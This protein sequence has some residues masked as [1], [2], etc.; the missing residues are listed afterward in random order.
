LSEQ[1]LA[2]LRNA[3]IEGDDG[4]LELETLTAQ[5]IS[6][7]MAAMLEA[8]PSLL[9]PE[10]AAAELGKILGPRRAGGDRVPA[11]SHRIKV[12]LRRTGGEK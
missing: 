10:T 11:R 5:Q 1:Q 6:E 3:R 4:P 12:A 9:D 8:N 2:I 7:G